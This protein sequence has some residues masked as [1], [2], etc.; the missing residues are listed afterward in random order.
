[1]NF[2]TL[3]QDIEDII[4]LN[5]DFSRTVLTISDTVLERLNNE[6]VEQ[7]PS[8]LL[9][10]FKN[11]EIDETIEKSPE[12]VGEFIRLNYPKLFDYIC[13]QIEE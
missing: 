9:D 10:P 5:A 11:G 1:M 12:D 3:S 7:D 13:Q 4:K 2:T 6:A 8:I